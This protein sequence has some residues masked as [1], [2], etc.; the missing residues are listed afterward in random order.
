MRSV[1]TNYRLYPV[2][3]LVLALGFA[4]AST[5]AQAALHVSVTTAADTSVAGFCSLRQAFVVMNTRSASQSSCVAT[6]I[7]GLTDVVSFDTSTLAPGGANAITLAD[8]SGTL[9]ITAMDLLIDGSANGNVTIQRGRPSSDN[10]SSFGVLSDSSLTGPLTLDHL[11]VR[12]GRV[13]VPS[14]GHYAVGGGD[15]CACVHLSV[16]D[17][18]I[19][20]KSVTATFGAN[21]LA[22]GY[23]GGL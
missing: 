16:I 1:P 2:R 18:T 22:S 17:S 11:T 8:I 3:P 6:T 15:A 23:G 12:N 14:S 21:A 9:E 7:A 5:G 20:D 4:M 10:T 19:S 13:S